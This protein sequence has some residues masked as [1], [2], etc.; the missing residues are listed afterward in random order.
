MTR[1]LGIVDTEALAF[2]GYWLMLPVVL[3]SSTLVVVFVLLVSLAMVSMA[4]MKGLGSASMP[5]A[6]RPPLLLRR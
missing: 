3:C 6:K 2:R 5:S 4:S 1:T